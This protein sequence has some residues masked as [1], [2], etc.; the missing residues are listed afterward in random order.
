MSHPCKF[1]DLVR[2]VSLLLDEINQVRQSCNRIGHQANT[3]FGT[4]L[5]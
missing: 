3:L 2:F 4:Y 1:Q 5:I